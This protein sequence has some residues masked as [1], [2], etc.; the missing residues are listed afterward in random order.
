[1]AVLFLKFSASVRFLRFGTRDG[2]SLIERIAEK[3]DIKRRRQRYRSQNV[4]VNQ[5]SIQ[6]VNE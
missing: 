2:K 6:E 5:K 3:R 1:M 4:H